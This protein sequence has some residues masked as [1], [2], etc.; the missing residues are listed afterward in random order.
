M[1]DEIPCTTCKYGNREAICTYILA[2]QHRR[3]CPA[4]IGC[5]VYEKVES[6]RERQKLSLAPNLN[7]KSLDKTEAY[8][9]YKAGKNDREIAEAMHLQ[10]SAVSYW[11]IQNK[12]PSQ[13]AIYAS[14]QLKQLCDL[15]ETGAS[16]KEIGEALGVGIYRVKAIRSKHGLRRSDHLRAGSSDR[17]QR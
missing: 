2:A 9:L 6:R 1:P 11:R 4:G 15:F 8:R 17:P 5:T 3:P 12:L 16:D 7:R 14:N 13:T 10:T